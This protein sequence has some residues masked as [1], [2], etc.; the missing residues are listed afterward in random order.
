MQLGG[1]RF[2]WGRKNLRDPGVARQQYIAALRAAG[3]H[4]IAPLLAFAR[5]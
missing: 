4:D 3:S 2:S 1:K 5:E